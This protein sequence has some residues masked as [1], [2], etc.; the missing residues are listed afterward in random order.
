MIL[1][2]SI[3]AQFEHFLEIE[4]KLR[5]GRLPQWDLV[6]LLLLQQGHFLVDC[7]VVNLKVNTLHL[8]LHP[9]TWRFMFRILNIREELPLVDFLSFS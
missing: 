7:F 5:A 8:A 3:R 1:K 9:E 4:V 6:G 2:K